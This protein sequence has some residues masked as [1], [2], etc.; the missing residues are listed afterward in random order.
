MKYE[1]K[2]EWQCNLVSIGHRDSHVQH[3]I[4]DAEYN[5]DGHA[6]YREPGRPNLGN[7]SSDHKSAVTPGDGAEYCPS[8]LFCLNHMFTC[9]V[10]NETTRHLIISHRSVNFAALPSIWT[11]LVQAPKARGTEVEPLLDRYASGE[12]RPERN[13]ENSPNKY[14]PESRAL[15]SSGEAFTSRRKCATVMQGTTPRL[16]PSYMTPKK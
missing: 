14:R 2:K 6:I 5:S 3:V 12:R 4:N 13:G 15:L 7:L 11:E 9:L 8:C 16:H 1:A 10:L